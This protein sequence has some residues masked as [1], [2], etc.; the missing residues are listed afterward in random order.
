MNLL[1]DSGY[2]EYS[3]QSSIILGVMSVLATYGSSLIIDKLGR[4]TL[5]LYSIVV[6][7][8]CTF[9]IG[10]FFCA[11]YYNYDTSFIKF[12]PLFSLC[13]FIIMFSIGFGPI[14]WMMMAEI[15]PAQIK[16]KLMY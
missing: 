12:I 11:K 13:L 14:P 5:L 1:Q 4:K 9:L 2:Q 6:M 15:F 7:A 16:S 10:G 3:D 8:I